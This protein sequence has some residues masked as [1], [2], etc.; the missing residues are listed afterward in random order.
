MIVE[1]IQ[2]YCTYEIKL[3]N[4]INKY[5]TIRLACPQTLDQHIKQRPQLGTSSLV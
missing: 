5:N 1:Q 3:L 2:N 4:M